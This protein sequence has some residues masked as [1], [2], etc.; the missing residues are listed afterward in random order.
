[1]K[2]LLSTLCIA[3]VTQATLAAPAAAPPAPVKL[4]VD[5]SEVKGPMTPIWAWFGYDEPNYTTTPNG[6]KLLSDIAELSPVP[7]YVRAHNLMTSGDGSHALK[8][9][10]TGMYSEDANGKPVY[11]WT[12]VDQ[13]FDTYVQR[14]MKP[15]AQ[16]G[17]MPEA[18]SQRPQPYQHKWKPGVRYEEIMT[19][20]ATP[21]KDYDK[22][23][24]LIYQWVRHCVERYGQ[25]EVE[26]WYWEVWNE[27]D[28]FY[29]IAPDVK[30]E[31]FK[32]YDYAADAVKRALPTARMGGPHTAGAGPF[33]DDF[34][35][36][37][38]TEKNYA[39]G[40][41]GAPLDFVA[42]HAKGA[43][44]VVNGVV[45]M[46]MGIHFRRLDDGFAI[47]QKYPQLKG[48]P[49]IIGESD[50]EGC[51]ACGMA[52]NPENAYRNGTLYA[53]YTAASI[54]RKFDLAD[55][56]GVNLIGAV[57]WSFLFEDQPWF[58]G[59]RDLATNGVNKP[60]LNVF[61]MFGMMRGERVAVSGDQAHDAFSIR[62]GG[63]R[64][65]RTD[66]NALAARDQRSVAVMLW[67]YHDDDIIDAGSEVAL[68]IGAIPAGQVKMR[69]YRIDQETSNSYTAWKRMGSPANPTPDQIRALQQASELAQLGGQETIKVQNG[70]ALIK[71]RLPRQAVS[72]LTITY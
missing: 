5:L 69:H 27:P 50:P 21:P 34:L 71:M 61:R 4:T 13:I 60:V 58:A 56:R 64:G 45:R 31:Y 17:F 49:V 39:T 68:E 26:S 32:M 16:I 37:V 12:I 38:L 18:L 14:G 3:A 63:V 47:V 44:K 11:N 53:S 33:M 1:M 70:K 36:H 57:N 66:I 6:K 19:G 62:A 29:L 54:A 30:R 43:P 24:E 48:M 65:A 51:A 67:N 25:K 40:K 2:K 72:L 9:G 22:W 28:G 41:V 8:W 7:V 59:F 23:A 15:L 46:D 10:S 42:F 35:K 55:R 20:W 52:T